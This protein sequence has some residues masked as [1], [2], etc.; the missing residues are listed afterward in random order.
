M[1][2]RD[3][4]ESEIRDSATV[5]KAGPRYVAEGEYEGRST[6]VQNGSPEGALQSLVSKLHLR[7]SQEERQESQRQ[8]RKD[9]REAKRQ[10]AQQRDQRDIRRQREYMEHNAKHLEETSTHD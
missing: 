8:W 10:R 1:V 9:A 2:D 7:I 5:S 3:A 4:I 6:A